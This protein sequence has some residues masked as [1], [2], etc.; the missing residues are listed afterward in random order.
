MPNG[1][2]S[3]SGK[4]VVVTGGTSGIGLMIAR[5]FVEAGARVYVSSRKAD[6]CAQTA[7][8]LGALGTC[9]GIPADM[10]KPEGIAALVAAVG[11]EEDALDVL[12][13]NAGATWGAPIEEY[14]SAGFDKVMNLNVR[15]PFDLSV[16]FLPL[17]RAG[18]S[19]EE[20][21]RI[22]NTTSVE[23]SVVPQWENYA[24]PA[25]KAAL[26]MLTRHLAWRLARDHITVNA[27]AP[28]PFPSKMIAFAH[29][30]PAAWRRIERSVPLGRAGA[31]D[32]A[33]GAAIFLASRA[34][35]Y[36]T[37]AVL[38]LDGGLAGAGRMG[39]D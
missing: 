17:L 31:P 5:G 26:N 23:G 25:S 37:G 29:E 30:D 22:V 28:G 2:F 33:A 21:A 35:S 13:N 6:G 34:A 16:A 20:P 12:V 27:I 7:Q 10:S 38:P 19:A 9:V 24:Y 36:I 1:L 32:D 39:A 14:P 4:V 15:A 3:V 8:E 11:A 18:A